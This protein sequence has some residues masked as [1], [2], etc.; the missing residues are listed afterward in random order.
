MACTASLSFRSLCAV[1]CGDCRHLMPDRRQ[2]A[3]VSLADVERRR[4]SNWIPAAPPPG[5][6]DLLVAGQ[7]AGTS[8]GAVSSRNAALLLVCLLMAFNILD[9]TL[10]IRAF[11]LGFAEANPFMAGLFDLSVPLGML[12]KFLMVGAGGLLL[13]RLSHLPLARRGMVAVTG[14]YGAVVAY[15]LL[16]QFAL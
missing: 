15:H 6:A 13:W 8:A 12:A 1:T 16:F 3:V 7:P 10:T 9:I 14:C 4:R 5:S 2:G 11:T